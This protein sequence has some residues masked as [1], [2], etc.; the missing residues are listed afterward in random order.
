MTIPTGCW[1]L[2]S[3]QSPKQQVSRSLFLQG[4]EFVQSDMNYLNIRKEIWMIEKGQAAVTG[5]RIYFLDNLRTFMIFLV[6]LY[7][8]GIVYE[9]SG[10]AASWWIVDDPSANDLSGILNLIIDIFVMP[11]IFFISGFFTPLSIFTLTTE[12]LVKVGYGFCLFFF[13]STYCI[14]FFQK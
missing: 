9:S 5:N 6:V 10:F 11:T 3:K 2:L 8:A 12:F 14:F 4:I 7:H 1:F 13:Y